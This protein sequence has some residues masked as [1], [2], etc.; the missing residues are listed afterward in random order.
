MS[1]I[2]EYISLCKHATSVFISQFVPLATSGSL[3]RQRNVS[4]VVSIKINFSNVEAKSNANRESIEDK[5]IQFTQ[6]KLVQ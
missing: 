5:G 2:K 4:E 3:C 6:G 1:N